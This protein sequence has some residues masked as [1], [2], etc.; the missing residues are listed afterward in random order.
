MSRLLEEAAAD[1]AAA[2]SGDC[3]KAD[4]FKVY[5]DDKCTTEDA[6]A[7]SPADGGFDKHGCTKQGE[8]GAEFY[9]MMDCSTN[10][11]KYTAH[12]ADDCSDDALMEMT[13]TADEN[14]VADCI[15]L[16]EDA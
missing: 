13:M 12:T 15:V 2:F 14:G 3:F 1:D 6:E 7:D 9:A 4:T 8:E 11:F 16:I 5:T 10:V